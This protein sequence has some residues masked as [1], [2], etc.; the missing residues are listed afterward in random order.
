MVERGK[1]HCGTHKWKEKN[2]MLYTQ[3]KIAKYVFTE[4]IPKKIILGGIRLIQPRGF[5][6]VL[7]H[8]CDCR[9]VNASLI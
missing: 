5:L 6:N 1:Q 7:V 3:Q 4:G 2:S 9:L 8:L